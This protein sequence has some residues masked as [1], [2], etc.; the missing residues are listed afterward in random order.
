MSSTLIRPASRRAGEWTTDA[1]V[2]LAR[3]SRL[4]EHRRRAGRSGFVGLALLLVISFMAAL[5]FGAVKLPLADVLAA[6]AGKAP[7]GAE[8][9]V[10]IMQA[11]RLPRALLALCVGALLA[12]SG[13]LLQGLF[14]NPLADP[15]LI[16]VTAGASVGASAVIVTGAVGSGALAGLSLVALGA[17]GG[18]FV[19]VW[20]VYRASTSVTGTSVAT[21]L[22]MGIAVSALAGSV[23]GLMEYFADNQSLRRISL[24]RM[25]GLDGAS[26]GRVVFT[27][28]LLAVQLLAMGYFARPLNALLL[29]ESQARHLGVDVERVKIRLILVVAAGVGIAVAMAG[30]IAFV[31]LVVPHMVRLWVGPD[32]RL[33][34]PLSALGGASL[35]LLADVLART[36]MAP[37]ELPV[38]LITALLG[39]PFFIVLLRQWR[40]GELA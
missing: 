39:A 18:G 17:F 13:A 3:V 32:H 8:Y 19:A 22:L 36:L 33:L 35:L 21:M 26:G 6:L 31:G 7:A 29:G 27:G 34:L 9:T 4:S 30:A 12:V 15:S 40:M 10:Q 16:G 2:E 24:W 37:V 1:P 28:L 14:R 20:L 38:G 11:I 5:V 25:G 23:T